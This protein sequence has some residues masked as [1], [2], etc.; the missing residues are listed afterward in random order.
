MR[1]SFVDVQIGDNA[2]SSQFPVRSRCVAQEIALTFNGVHVLPPSVSNRPVR[3]SRVS[4]LQRD[5][6]AVDLAC[7]LV[8]HIVVFLG[9]HGIAILRVIQLNSGG[10]A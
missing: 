4:L 6:Y 1:H 10:E 5:H 7:E 3:V 9:Y 8:R 2:S